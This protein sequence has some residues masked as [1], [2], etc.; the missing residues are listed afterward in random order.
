[1]E[2]GIYNISNNR[3]AIIDD[4]DVFHS[5][6][7]LQETFETLHSFHVNRPVIKLIN[8]PFWIEKMDESEDNHSSVKVDYIVALARS[9]NPE[10]KSFDILK[11]SLSDLLT[12]QSDKFVS[13]GS[14]LTP[15]LESFAFDTTSNSGNGASLFRTYHSLIANGKK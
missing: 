3:N 12:G 8:V 10:K 6:L 7:F 11:I 9:S 15:R 5:I 1:M 13:F 14:T 4:F 2:S